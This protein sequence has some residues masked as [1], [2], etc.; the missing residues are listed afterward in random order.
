MKAVLARA[1]RVGWL[2]CALI[3]LASASMLA[4]S[5]AIGVTPADEV[6][7]S[8]L[9]SFRPPSLQHEAADHRQI[10]LG[11]TLFFDPILSRSSSMAC[12]SCHNPGLSWADGLKR[13]IGDIGSPM[14][15]RSPTLI[16]VSG[17]DRF[18][19]DGKFPD[20]ESVTFA[21]ISGHANMN[22]P[23]QEA[24]DRLRKNAVYVEMFNRVF[25]GQGLTHATVTEAIAAFERTIVSGPAP[26]DRYVA[27][28]RT[29]ISKEA[30]RG[31]VLFTGKANCS[32]CHSG[33]AFTD[34]SFHDI[35]SATG[36][37]IGRGRLFPTSRKLKYGFKTPTLRDVARRAPY[38]HDG[39]EPDLQA[40]IELYDKGGID[41]PSRSE[42]IH[43]LG[44][45][46]RDKTDLIAFLDT[47]TQ[48][49]V[50]VPTPVLPR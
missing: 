45:T 29:A 3:V 5:G 4:S 33:W 32:Q 36:G 38:M 8:I 44:L 49:P 1:F 34:G 17:L 47:L 24:M 30:K 11:R 25:P 22:L 15:L 12:A 42:L 18:G 27:G 48:A 26:F 46:V 28:D 41:R 6:P 50:S 20:I 39:S 23:E 35:G 16:D 13:A 40:V 37:D 31:F 21:A 2:P 43:P 10:Q 14:S 7:A 9:R 19:W